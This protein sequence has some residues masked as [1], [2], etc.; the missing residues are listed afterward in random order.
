MTPPRFTASV[1]VFLRYLGHLA[2]WVDQAEATGDPSVLTARLAPDMLPF[3]TQVEVAANF[4]LRTCFPL[5]GLPV[6]PYGDQP[7]TADGMRRRLARVSALVAALDPA[8]FA[9]ARSVADDAGQV[10]LVLPSDDFLHLYALPNFFFHLGAA[11]HIL[12]HAG[13]PLGKA[14]FD[15]FHVYG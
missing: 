15:G 10:R 2:K 13:L 4:A 1:P 12:R 7:P 3:H 14:D 9:I 11:Y 5:A 6:P 8:A